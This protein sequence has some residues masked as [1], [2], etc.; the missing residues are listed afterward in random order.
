MKKKYLLIAL[1]TF[2]LTSSLQA[3]EVIFED[4][5]ESGYTDATSIITVNGWQSWAGD[6]ATPVVESKNSPSTGVDS[7]D[8][9][10]EILTGGYTTVARNY[11][12]KSGET[13]EFKLSYRRSGTGTLKLQV[14]DNS[15]AIVAVSENVNSDVWAELMVSFEANADENHSF[16]FIQNWGTG[17]MAF[18]NVS[19]KCTTCSTASIADN[20]AFEFAMYPNPA[21]DFI[22]FK[23]Q[24]ELSSIKVYNII[25][26]EVLS[27]NKLSQKTVNVSKFEKGVYIMKIEAK[28]GSLVSRKFVKN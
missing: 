6:G 25:G 23:T 3:Q 9:Y 26:K 28:N 17:P 18:D 27:L 20:D 16:R 10:A 21:N 12:L 15:N 4:D 2:V 22:T 14:H 13:Y 11:P 7:S 24:E 1:F 8:W 19:I 5:F